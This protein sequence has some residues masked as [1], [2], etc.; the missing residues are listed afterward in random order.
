[1][2]PP[3]IVAFEPPTETQLVAVGYGPDRHEK[4]QIV[5]LAD[6][7]VRLGVSRKQA[8]HLI[9]RLRKLLQLPI[10]DRQEN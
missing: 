2:R 4:L 5:L 10:F 6:N 8:R 9:G 1:M 7:G 3:D